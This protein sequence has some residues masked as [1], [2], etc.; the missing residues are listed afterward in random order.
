[1]AFMKEEEFVGVGVDYC[2][3]DLKVF[4]GNGSPSDKQARMQRQ[5]GNI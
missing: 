1:M 4:L 2:P 5:G 3:G